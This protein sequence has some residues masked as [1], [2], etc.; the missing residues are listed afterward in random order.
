MWIY[1]LDSLRF[2]AVNN[3]TMEHYGYS[4]EEFLQMTIKDIRPENDVP[5]LLE[6]VAR[7]T[8]GLD[9]AGT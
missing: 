1:D 3:A 2:L 8:S 5:A 9:H 6:N 7:V 4:A